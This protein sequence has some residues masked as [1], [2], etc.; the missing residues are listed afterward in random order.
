MR[1]LA[2]SIADGV[3]L[4][5]LK[6][7]PTTDSAHQYKEGKGSSKSTETSI[8]TITNKWRC[9]DGKHFFKMMETR[10]ELSATQYYQSK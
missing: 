8:K 4:M 2:G 7:L 5:P 10:D 1:S 6:Y 3:Q 9:W